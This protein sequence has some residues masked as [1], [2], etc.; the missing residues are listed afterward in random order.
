MLVLDLVVGVGSSVYMKGTTCPP[1]SLDLQVPQTPSCGHCGHKFPLRECLAWLPTT[2]KEAL[3]VSKEAPQ[4][5]LMHLA[6][7]ARW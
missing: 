7:L 3:V 4:V 2:S 5:C 6:C 1:T